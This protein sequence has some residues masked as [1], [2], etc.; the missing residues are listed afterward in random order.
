MK[1]FLAL[2]L[3][4]AT[5]IVT[6]ACADSG[7]KKPLD[8][9][10]TTENVITE[11]TTEEEMSTYLQ[12][13]LPERLD[14]NGKTV[15]IHT[16]GDYNSADEIAVED[17]TNQVYEA[18]YNRNMAVEEKLKVSIEVF[19]SAAWD[20]YYTVANSQ[21][22][23]SIS[24]GDAA[25]DIVSGW[26]PCIP[27][28]AIE[29]LMTDLNTLDYI[30]TDM[31]WWTQSLV[32]ELTVG[33]KL[34]FVTGDISVFTMIGAMRIF[35][36]NSSLAEENEIPN[37]YDVVN[38]GDWTIDYVTQL[39]KNIYKD[40]GDSQVDD[41]DTFGLQMGCSNDVDG[42]VGAARVKM[43][44]RDEN[45]LQYLNMPVEK[46]SNL[47]DKLYNLM[48]ESQGTYVTPADAADV[49]FKMMQENR[50]L[51]APF[52][53]D[54]LRIAFNDLKSDFMVLPYPKLD[55]SQKEYGTRIQDV[56]QIWGIPTDITGDKLSAA[57]ATLE[58]LACESYNSVTSVYFDTALKGRY[59]RDEE[60]KA[61]MDLIKNSVFVSFE[62]IYNNLMGNP[63]Y[64]LRNM[65]GV[66]NRDFMSYWEKRETA[67]DE[68][69]DKVIEKLIDPSI[70]KAA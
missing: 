5:I 21:L 27:E 48:Y 28:L 29:G 4:A 41:K 54:T 6:A 17:T 24:S 22:R 35:V 58:A 32:E 16:R 44:Q 8:S 14:F 46:M 52:P 69:F 49:A 30:G 57:S 15:V 63:C 70:E 7:Q 67:I 66:K 13:N 9:S 37:L 59:T 39:T 50:L 31:P 10:G 20:S 40:N 55:E 25:F 47:V 2:I 38:N 26:S 56:L 60:S 42:F 68:A 53:M 45:G 19:R 65:L 36:C 43:S 12:S 23:A 18:I 1:R 34:H 51:L 61:M 11:G 64:T 62:M 33:G 3:A